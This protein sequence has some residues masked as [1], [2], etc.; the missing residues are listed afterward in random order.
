MPTTLR[1]GA[2]GL[3][4]SHRSPTELSTPLSAMDFRG[5]A[6]YV[7]ETKGFAA[8]NVEIGAKLAPASPQPHPLGQEGIA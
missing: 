8:R 7:V 4:S 1:P 6:R 5:E 2:K 3:K